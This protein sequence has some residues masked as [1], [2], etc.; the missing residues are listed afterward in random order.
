[1]ERDRQRGQPDL[2]DPDNGVWRGRRVARRFVSPD[3]MIVLVGKTAEDND[4]LSLKL[5]APRDFWMH[6]AAESGS[7]VVI[8]NPDG[9]STL[10]RATAQ[11]AAALAARYSKARRGG[12][13]A[14][15]LAQV[16]DVSKPRGLPPGKV[17]LAR[18][19]TIHASPAADE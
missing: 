16:A 17:Q 4:T 12:R 5:G 2:S 1:M 10:P 15:H 18:Y 14:V 8:R 9:L 7:H 19:R 6:V 13:V 11:Y 3:G